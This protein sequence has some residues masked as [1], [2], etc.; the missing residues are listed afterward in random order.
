AGL[1]EAQ[2]D[3]RERGRRRRAI[4]QAVAARAAARLDPFE[5]LAEA[6]KGFR[7]LDLAADI[8]H[9]GQEPPR[10]VRI[11]LLRRELCE[12]FFELGAEDLGRH[13]AARDADNA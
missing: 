10:D 6:C 7:L 5:L 11:H 9:A 12:T 1:A 3:R 13:F 2:R 4:E 8:R